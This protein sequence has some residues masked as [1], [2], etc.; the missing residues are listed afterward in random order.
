MLYPIEH[1]LRLRLSAC[2]RF[3]AFVEDADLFDAAHFRLSRAEAA[4]MDSQTRML[5][6][7]ILS[8][9][10]HRLLKGPVTLE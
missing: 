6:Q 7:V 3:G 2:H 8:S 9:A 10:P 4:A 5:L 1:N